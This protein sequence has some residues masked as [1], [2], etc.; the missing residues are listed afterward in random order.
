M[1]NIKIFNKLTKRQN[2]VKGIAKQLRAGTLKLKDVEIPNTIVWDNGTKRFTANNKRNIK[3]R[4]NQESLRRNN[5]IKQLDTK[6]DV[7]VIFNDKTGVVIDKKKFLDNLLKMVSPNKRYLITLESGKVFTLNAQSINAIKKII[8]DGFEEVNEETSD[9]TIYN[10][11]VSIDNINIREVFGYKALIDGSF[12]PY[13]HTCGLMIDDL[14]RY[15]IHFDADSMSNTKIKDESYTENCLIRAFISS[16]LIPTSIINSIKFSFKSGNIPQRDLKRVAE[17]FGLYIT[18]KRDEANKNIRKYGNKDG[19]HIP[20]GIIEDHYFLIEKTNYTKYSVKNYHELDKKSHWNV[21]KMEGTR[22]RKRPEAVISSWDL[23][24]TLIENKDVLLRSLNDCNTEFQKTEYWNKKMVIDCLEFEENCCKLTEYKP[25]EIKKGKRILE[26]IDFETFNMC[27]SD[28]P[29]SMYKTT[30]MYDKIWEKDKSKT[31]H[32]PFMLCSYDDKYDIYNTYTGENCGKKYLEN[33]CKLYGSTKTPSKDKV[34]K[35]I[36]PTLIIFAHNAGYDIRFIEEYL[37]RLT[38]IENGHSLICATGQFTSGGKTINV[39]IRDSK[40][41]ITSPL[42]GFAKMFGLDVTKEYMPY[43]LYTLETI[44]NGYMKYDD[45]KDFAEKEGKLSNLIECVEKSNSLKDGVI[46]MLKYAEYYCIKDVEVLRHGFNTFAGWIKDALDID[47]LQFYTIPSI[48]HEFFMKKGCYDDTYALSGVVREFINKCLLG[49]RTMMCQNEK[50]KHAVNKIADFDGVSLYPSA[51]KAMRGFLKGTPKIITQDVDWMSMDGFFVELKVINIGKHRKFPMMNIMT[52]DGTRKYT[53]DINDFKDNIYVDREMLSILTEYHQIE[54]ELVKGYYFN[55]GFNTKINTVIQ[56]VFNN[57][58]KAKNE[59]VLNDGTKKEWTILECLT[60]NKDG[61]NIPGLWVDDNKDKVK[62]FCNPI[63]EIWKLVMNSGYGKSITKPHDTE[64]KYITGKENLD[65]H[66]YRNYNW[67]IET[68]TVPCEW[69]DKYKVKQLKPIHNHFNYCH[70][71][72][73][74][75]SMSKR[76]MADVMYLA[77]DNDIDM[78]YTDTDSIHMNLDD[79]NPL[80]ELFKN[81][82]NRELIGQALGQFHT[83]FDLNGCKDVYSEKFIAVGKKC[84]IDS[85]VGINKKTGKEERGYHIRLKGVPNKS[86]WNVV[87]KKYGG[88][89]MKLY[90]ELHA[91]EKVSFDLT[92]GYVDGVCDVSLP[93]FE[94]KSNLLI[95][96]KNSFERDMKFL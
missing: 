43:S 8:K 67:V 89:P 50:Q 62:S 45:V 39:E 96:N 80:G 56:E 94:F 52:E 72:I 5:S 29:T 93:C 22:L 57:R 41:L 66:I 31:I 84:Y 36:I 28:K 35:Q 83:D 86:I 73:E 87:H 32:K 15:D 20:L 13:F 6:S 63:Q 77:E 68:N 42:A 12:F 37:N 30:D 40:K 21:L 69:T 81:K 92:K 24:K 9:K 60:T 90:E 33:R 51:M 79:V 26:F 49:G 11:L 64:D 14:K 23:I 46:D 74:I 34:E 19:I 91:G 82:Y 71:G 16:G 76:I 53:D 58:L 27:S 3:K 61:K 85:L 1:E 17:S 55:E 59:T 18:V 47:V 2:G 88:N 4:I 75:L 7:N 54:F 44:T 95:C 48:A 78:Y 38:K 10:S 25:R 70:I 65:K